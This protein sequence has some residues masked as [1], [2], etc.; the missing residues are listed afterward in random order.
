[1]PKQQ[2]AIRM[3][4]KGQL[5]AM[6]QLESRSDEELAAETRYRAAAQ[7]ILGARAAE[8]Y[9]AKAARAALPE[10]ARR[11]SA[12]AAHADSADG[13][14]LAGA[15]RAPCGRSQGCDRPSGC[16]GPHLRP[17]VHAADRR[18]HRAAVE[19]RHLR[20]DPRHRHRRWPRSSRSSGSA[21]ASSRASARRPAGSRW[22]SRSST[23]S[24]LA[25]VAVGIAIFFGRR[26]SKAA[27]AKR[28][29]AQAA[30]SGGR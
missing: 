30:R 18:T 3:E 13:R 22:T 10:G 25:L 4:Q 7:A 19:R 23:A 24:S 26:R 14:R 16:R 9:D 2:R 17:A 11:G 6:Q 27:L 20:P 1:M 8:K 5:A 12:S 29:E 28:R 15:G 21:S